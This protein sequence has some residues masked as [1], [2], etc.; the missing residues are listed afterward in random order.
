ME[1]NQVNW[2]LS[3][4]L[5]PWASP[6]RRKSIFKGSNLLKK[7]QIVDLHVVVIVNCDL[8]YAEEIGSKV[9]KTNLVR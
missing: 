7:I 3:F 8:I 4:E 6:R 5:I 9:L 1:W 2:V